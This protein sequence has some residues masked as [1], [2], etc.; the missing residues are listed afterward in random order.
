MTD[1]DLLITIDTKLDGIISK[2]SD[3]ETRIRNLEGLSGKI[4]GIAIASSLVLGFL[5]D[6]VKRKVFSA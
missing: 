6:W 3:Q 4:L 1:H 5:L 2:Q